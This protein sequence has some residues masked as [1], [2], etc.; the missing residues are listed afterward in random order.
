MQDW[1]K[2][3]LDKSERRRRRA[4][5]NRLIRRCILIVLISLLILAGLWLVNESMELIA[6][7]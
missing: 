7:R 4:R 2:A 5:R 1:E 3:F 6:I